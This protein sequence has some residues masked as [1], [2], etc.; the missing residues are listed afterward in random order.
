[1]MTTPLYTAQ[2]AHNRHTFLMLMWT[3][4]YPARA[5]RLD[6]AY[7]MR[8]IADCLLD[9]EASYFTNDEALA[10]HLRRTTA[11]HESVERADYVFIPKLTDE[12][13][14]ALRAAKIG[15][16]L[17]PDQAATL[18]VGCTALGGQPAHDLSFNPSQNPP[19]G[20][21]TRLKLSG[22][23]IQGTAEVS[24]S[25]IPTAFWELRNQ[26]RRYPLGWDVYLVAGDSLIGIPRSTTLTVMEG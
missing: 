21:A 15:S 6:A 23:G 20:N 22:A 11:R 19:N 2:E 1:M 25:G 5:Y 9:L 14:P 12:G 4:S 18:I 3:F 26:T 16:M 24:V 8:A 7:P 17:F 13:L 10:V